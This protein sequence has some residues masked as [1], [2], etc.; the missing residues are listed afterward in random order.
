VRRA[1]RVP[2][3]D[4]TALW[5]GRITLGT[6]VG[7]FGLALLALLLSAE[8]PWLA[9]GGLF[10]GALFGVVIIAWSVAHFA[11]VWHQDQAGYVSKDDVT[12]WDAREDSKLGGL[13]PF[14][15]LLASPEQR[16]ILQ[17]LGQDAPTGKPRRWYWKR[18]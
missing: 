8:L 10:F 2:I 1:M 4:R 11:M 16:R 5:I 17:F 3:S 6:V 7:A 15:Y 14:T 12:E 13:V 18:F 9:N